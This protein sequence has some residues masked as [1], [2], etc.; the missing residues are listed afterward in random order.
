MTI[1]VALLAAGLLAPGCVQ[2]QDDDLEGAYTTEQAALLSYDSPRLNWIMYD[3]PGGA[4]LTRRDAATGAVSVTRNHQFSS[5]WD[6]VG[7]A[8]NKLLWQRTD[9]DQTNLWTIDD[10][11]NFVRF[12]SL[13]PPWQGF[14]AVGISAMQDGCTDL[15]PEFRQYGV[16]FFRQGFFPYLQI[17]D[18]T[19]QQVGGHWI[20]QYEWGYALEDLRL[21]HYGRWNMLW[22]NESGDAVVIKIDDL[23]AS[24]I[25]QRTDI[26]RANPGPND[27]PA[28]GQ[29][30]VAESYVK[31]QD[32]S[33]SGFAD[34]ILWR[35]PDSTTLIQTVDQLGDEFTTYSIA[36]P[37]A[38]Q[39]WSADS[40][41]G[42]DPSELICLQPLGPP[43][44]GP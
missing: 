40:L 37:N 14:K 3:R 18:D 27:K 39:G 8:G 41:S 28:P 2:D 34:H 17:V 31:A 33:T 12:A 9:I 29:G 23:S 1:V 30:F 19:G 36:H 10:A 21:D 20:Y 15:L 44:D 26:Y 43:Y 42:A 38:G 7:V 35:G 16:L 25:R 24:W 6:A 11:G 22:G 4:S 5:H 32:F 13:T